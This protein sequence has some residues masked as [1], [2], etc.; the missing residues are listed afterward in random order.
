MELLHILEVDLY[1]DT[2][3]Q[4]GAAEFSTRYAQYQPGSTLTTFHFTDPVVL[5]SALADLAAFA[6]P[7]QHI[8]AF[9]F[10][11][12]ELKDY[13]AFFFGLP[14]LY[15]VLTPQ[16][17]NLKAIKKR[18]MVK[19][20]ATGR[21]IFSQR[22]KE[23][24]ESLVPEAHW[25]ELTSAEGQWFWLDIQT[26]LRDPLRIIHPFEVIENEKRPGTYRLVYDGRAIIS[27]WDMDQLRQCGVC[28]S[29]RM[30][31]GAQVLQCYP[32]PMLASGLLMHALHPFLKG[33]EKSTFSVALSPEHPL[34][35]ASVERIDIWKTI[36]SRRCWQKAL[37]GR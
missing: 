14:C 31:V 17:V 24:I 7:F 22:I 21:M 36:N 27:Q 18:E 16:G 10:R 34:A 23:A 11:R 6:L 29:D 32:E 33:R 26:K 20:Y 37:T 5:A 1:G 2:G 8:Y 4:P 3:I 15:D 30:A 28:F 35:Q 19:D 13:P 9:K 12:A 25:Q